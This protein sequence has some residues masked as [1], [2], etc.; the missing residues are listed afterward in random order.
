MHDAVAKSYETLVVDDPDAPGMPTLP[1]VSTEELTMH[2]HVDGEW[3][4]R[5]PDLSETSCGRPFHS[6]FSTPRREELTGALCETCF[7][8]RERQRAQEH[9]DKLRAEAELGPTR[10]SPRSRK[11]TLR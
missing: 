4:R 8:P 6:Q 11:D 5:M 7:T 3:H 2:V 1:R 10:I 9:A